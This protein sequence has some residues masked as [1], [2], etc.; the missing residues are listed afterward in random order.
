MSLLILY[1][2]GSNYTENKGGRD[3]NQK[4]GDFTRASGKKL[5]D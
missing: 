3:Q 4:G 2:R 5:A 1:Q